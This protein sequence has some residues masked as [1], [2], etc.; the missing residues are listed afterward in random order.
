MWERLKSA[1]LDE[2]MQD[3]LI[4]AEEEAKKIYDDRER[5]V[6]TYDREYAERMD[7]VRRH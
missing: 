1:L 4:H 7:I 6:K 5:Y 3:R 2:Q